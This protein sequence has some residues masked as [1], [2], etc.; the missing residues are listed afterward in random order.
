M[1][2]RINGERKE[3]PSC[4]EEITTLQYEK[5]VKE[6]ELDKPIEE[7]DYFKLFN[8]LTDSNFTAVESTPELEAT[9]WN[10]IRWIVEQPFYFSEELPKV[11]KI[12]EVIVDIPRDI[13]GLSIG[14]NI[15]LKQALSKSKY[16]EANLSEAVAIY[17]Q[18]LYDK[19]KFNYDR[20]VELKKEIE[21]M[22]VYLIRPIGFFLFKNVNQ[23]GSGLTIFLKKMKINLMQK[24]GVASLTL[25][26]YQGFTRSLI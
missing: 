6:W 17:L 23:H 20:A 4:F 11:L 8:I 14:Q 26:K 15:H 7:R 13:R 1:V 25:H 21:Q 2:I 22:P 24:L 19:K 9:I 3:V 12:N 18:P 5:I 10:V 16:V